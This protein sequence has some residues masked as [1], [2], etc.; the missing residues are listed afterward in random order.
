MYF[1]GVETGAV[2][3]WGQADVNLHRLTERHERGGERPAASQLDRDTAAILYGCKLPVET[4][5]LKNRGSSWLP[6]AVSSVVEP[7][8]ALSTTTQQLAPPHHLVYVLY[9]HNA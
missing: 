3:T 6:G 2:L 5:R 1:Q 9:M 8:G 7:G 4:R